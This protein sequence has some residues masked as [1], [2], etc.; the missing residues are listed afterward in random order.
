VRSSVRI[1]RRSTGLIVA[2]F[3]AFSALAT[4]GACAHGS[5]QRD[6]TTV[7]DLLRPRAGVIVPSRSAFGQ[8]ADG[9][10]VTRL[11]TQP[12]TPESAVRISLIAHPALRA[13]YAE[14]GLA[15]ADVV[16]AAL[17][18]NPV[19]SFDRF[20]TGRFQEFGIAQSFIDL[21]SQP[22]RRRV[23][24]AEMESAR[25]R[26]ANVVFQHV[27]DV[28]SSLVEAVAAAQ[29]RDVSERAQAAAA[30]SAVA[31]TAIHAAGN[32][33]ELDLVSE[34]AAAAEFQAGAIHARGES[35]STREQLARALGVS[36]TGAA[37]ILQDRLPE[38]PAADPSVD[39]LV[40]LAA[41]SRLDLAAA[42]QDVNAAGK[43]LGITRRFRLLPDGTLSFAGEG[44]DGGPFKSGPGFSIP[45]PF[46]DRGQARML[47]AQ[48][49]L[50]AAVARHE[51]ITLSMRADVRAA[52]ALLTS[53]RARFE[54]YRLRVV[55]LRRRATEE[56]QLQYNAMAVSVFGLLQARQGELNAGQGYIEAMSDY[57]KAR[58]QL[59]RAVG[60]SLP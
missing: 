18:A 40:A 4:L 10:T 29:V 58:I 46:F 13:T 54:E 26:I 50:R 55:P 22:M 15:R 57:W 9:D 12:L 45:L 35:A 30:A 7:D 20:T 56:T 17:L 19:I 60:T 3:L 42:L 8:T 21:L 53:A 41:R 49:A 37:L 47:R 59:E 36:T 34:R 51:A 43:T 31:A 16:Q 23:A 28:R 5:L 33:Q 27:T 32:L 2:R 39:S 6:V 24:E 52:Y 38:L 14:L 11:L 1:H 44:E 48:S 25:L